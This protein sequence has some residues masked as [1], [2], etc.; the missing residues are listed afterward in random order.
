VD[1]LCELDPA[2]YVLDCLPNM[3]APLVEERT[4]VAVRKLRGAHAATPIVLV[5]M[6]YGDA[7]LKPHRM[8]RS[9]NANKAQ[10]AVC[11]RLVRAG[12]RN[13]H[14][15]RGEGLLGTDGEATIDGTHYTDL[16][17]LRYAAKLRPLLERLSPG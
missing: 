16:G 6:A 11:E 3:T 17:F 14:C 5:G 9:A 15:L 12:V 8:E 13:L 10:E 7:F 4:E 1:L 2:A